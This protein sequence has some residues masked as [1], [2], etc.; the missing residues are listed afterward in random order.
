ME[1]S[2]TQ[3]VQ[4]IHN[5]ELDGSTHLHLT[6]TTN[7]NILSLSLAIY[8]HIHTYMFLYTTNC[9]KIQ[10]VAVQHLLVY[11]ANDRAGLELNPRYFPFI[12]L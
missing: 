5:A 9:L 12:H 7:M 8:I 10:K 3:P 1:K 6:D 11:S 2:T 4:R